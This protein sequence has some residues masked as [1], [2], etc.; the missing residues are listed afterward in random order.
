MPARKRWRQPG[1]KRLTLSASPALFAPELAREFVGAGIR[2][3]R[4][5]NSVAHPTNAILLDDTYVAALR[6]EMSGTDRPERT[7]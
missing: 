7:S 5:T 1:P 6:S 4:S 3:V 2:S